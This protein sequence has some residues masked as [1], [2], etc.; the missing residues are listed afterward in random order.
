MLRTDWAPLLTMLIDANLPVSERAALFHASLARA[1]VDQ[2]CRLREA[3][4]EFTVGLSGGVFQNRVLTERAVEL[5]R[6]HGFDVRLGQQI[7]C[8]DAGIA[9]GQLIES[10]WRR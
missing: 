7:P 3:H 5:L 6:S 8:N 9:F 10:G 2:A 1:L 4:G